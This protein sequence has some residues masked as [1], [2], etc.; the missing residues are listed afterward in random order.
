[1]KGSRDLDDISDIDVSTTGL[2]PLE[3]RKCCLVEGAVRPLCQCLTKLRSHSL[4]NLLLKR[5]NLGG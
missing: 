2:E 1:M 3:V 5:G 4:S